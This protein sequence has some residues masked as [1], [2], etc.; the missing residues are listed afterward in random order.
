MIISPPERFFFV[1]EAPW[2]T[3]HSSKMEKGG[4]SMQDPENG[5]QR[6]NAALELAF[7]VGP[8][9]IGAMG[10]GWLIGGW[11]DAR[12]GTSPTALSICVLLGAL[13]GFVHIIRVARRL[14]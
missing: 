6:R 10:A 5:R 1:L 9:F 2:S 7:S 13:A 14:E 3:L 12:W 4:C 11:L 8:T